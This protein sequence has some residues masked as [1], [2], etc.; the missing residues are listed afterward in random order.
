MILDMLKAENVKIVEKVDD[1]KEAIAVSLKPLE[2]Q[3]YVTE[4]YAKAIV[5]ITLEYGPYYV[6]TENVA[7]IHGR[8]E[9]GVLNKQLAVTVLREPIKFSEDGYPV[10][11][12]VAL[13]ATDSESHLAVMQ[14][15]AELFMS[16]DAISDIINA[17]DASQIYEYLVEFD[18][19][20]QENN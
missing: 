13:A 11:L 14:T 1:W 19:K 17:E 20:T 18:K 4:D 8:P 12:L 5:D 10:R 15:L 2:E 3:G 7:L 6:L 9:T 16:E